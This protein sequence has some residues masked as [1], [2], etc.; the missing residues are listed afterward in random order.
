M[1]G[2]RSSKISHSL[3]NSFAG[4]LCEALSSVDFVFRKGFKANGIPQNKKLIVQS[5][6]GFTHRKMDPYQKT[7]K[8]RKV[9][10]H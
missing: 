1:S 5:T 4:I 7:I 3:L 8:K 9:P 6:A 2:V 10:I